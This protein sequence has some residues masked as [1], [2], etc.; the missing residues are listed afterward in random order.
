MAEC[1]RVPALDDVVVLDERWEFRVTRAE[2]RRIVTLEL[3]VL[4]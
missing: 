3:N 4:A 2:N 1:G